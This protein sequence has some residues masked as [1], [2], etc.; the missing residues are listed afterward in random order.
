MFSPDSWDYARPFTAEIL[1]GQEHTDSLGHTNNIVYTQWCQEIAWSHSTALGMSAEDYT[2]LG[3]AMAIHHAEYKYLAAAMPGEQLLL[4]TWITASDA[5]VNMERR[6]QL[7]NAETGKTIF[8][9]CW[10]LACIRLDNGRPAR[11][12]PEFLAVY[13]PAVVR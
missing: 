6:F 9:G 4:A 13:E 7:R 2:K 10:K 1:V 8:R 5:R 12:P 11:M 3:R